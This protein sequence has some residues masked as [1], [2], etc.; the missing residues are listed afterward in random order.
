[1]KKSF[2]RPIYLATALLLAACSTTPKL[3]APTPAMTGSGVFYADD[4]SS[5]SAM[6]YSNETVTLQF[7]DM[8]QQT[9]HIARS[10]SGARY[11]LDGQEWWEHHGEATYTVNGKK[12]FVGKLKQ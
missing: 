4:G 2:G 9:L 11:T 1:M 7:Q 5:I 10:A 8:T 12:I 3:S 6:Y